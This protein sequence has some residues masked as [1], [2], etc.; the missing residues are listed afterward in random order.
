V[1]RR[2][3]K[4]ALTGKRHPNN[5][6]KPMRL[7]QAASFL[8]VG[9]MLTTIGASGCAAST[10]VRQVFMALDSTGNRVRNVF[11]TDT[12]AIFCDI[13]WSGRGNDN[14][15][16]VVLLQTAGEPNL[17]DGSNNSQPLAGGTREWS[18]AEVAPTA[19]ISTVG[20]SFQPPQSDTGNE[21]PFPIGTWSC[22]VSVNGESAGSAEFTIVYPTP[23]CPQGG[24]QTSTDVASPDN[25]CVGYMTTLAPTGAAVCP[26]AGGTG[27]TCTC[28]GT[29][30]TRVWVCQ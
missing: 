9:G 30:E 20:V 3:H 11:Q 8:V 26:N 29:D 12:T 19:G 21:L 22:V 5:L 23:D 15:V 28:T 24:V 16:D 18:A 17:F 6:G 7:V 27:S 1:K 2:A 10:Q 14:T 13:I 25:S 4:K